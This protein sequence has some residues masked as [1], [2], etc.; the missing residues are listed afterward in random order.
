[1]ANNNINI[2]GKI[3][4]D[5][6]GAERALAAVSQRFR[7][8]TENG[9]TT[10]RT[11]VEQSKAL[12]N[13]GRAVK[14]QTDALG[15]LAKA[16]AEVARKVAATNKI[17]SDAKN[18]REV[19]SGTVELQN[20]RAL[21]EAARQQAIMSESSSRNQSRAT[22]DQIALDQQA[23]R[24]KRALA[25]A[26]AE[27]A[28]ALNGT[29]YALYDVARTATI[30]G[31]ALIA[32]GAAPVMV[33]AKWEKEFS[34]VRRTFGGT[35]EQVDVLRRSFVELAQ[36]IPVDWTALTEIGTLA[37]QLGVPSGQ[38]ADFTK[39][40]AQFSATTGV[41]V[42]DT[43]TALGR[44]NSLI[45]DVNGN[46]K[47]LA[48]SV[49]KVGV[50]SV[51][52]EQD[53]L[54]ISTQ[55]SFLGTQ[56][57][58]TSKEIVGLSGALASVGVP[59][60]LS[61]GVVT[62]TFG[63][64]G[65]AVADGG[66]A[67]ERFGKLAGMSGGEFQKAWNANAGDTFL[68]FMRGIQ[69]EGSNAEAAIR[70]L[71]ITSVRDVPVLIR[72]ANAAD[73]AGQKGALLAQTF[74]DAADAT[75]E[76]DRQYAIQ[77]SNLTDRIALLGNNVQAFFDAVGSGS[78]GPIGDVLTYF[79]KKL[80]ELTAFA[81]TDVGG[82]ILGIGAA[83]SILTGVL[84]LGAA[85]AAT[86]L[87]AYIGL[88]TAMRGLQ[89]G[90]GGATLSLGGLNTMLAATGPAGT[91]AAAGIGLVAKGLKAL[92]VIGL[93]LVVPEVIGEIAKAL[94]GYDEK[95]AKVVDKLNDSLSDTPN[96]AKSAVHGIRE[97]YDVA[98]GKQI[99]ENVQ[100]FRNE[101][102]QIG[103]SN[104]WGDVGHK[105]GD[106]NAQYERATYFI[107]QYSK[108]FDALV[109]QGRS[110]EAVDIFQ[111]FVKSASLGS[112]EIDALLSRA[113][114]I[115]Q[116]LSDTLIG[117]DVEVND[118]NLRAL[119]NGT[120]PE[121]K[122]SAKAAA[123]G[124]GELTDEEKAAEQAHTD[125]LKVITEGADSFVNIADTWES[126]SSG[127]RKA[128][129]EQADA[130]TDMSD[131][132]LNFFDQYSVNLDEY[133]RS[134]E[135]QAAAQE[136]WQANLFKLRAAG[137]SDEMLAEL[138]KL[139]VQGAP[140]VQ[141]F[142]DGTADKMQRF[143]ELL[144]RTGAEGPI[145]FADALSNASPT[146]IAAV[147]ALGDD[148]VNEIAG[149]LSRGEATLDQII[150]DYDLPPVD[151]DVDTPTAVYDTR[152]T[153]QAINSV[154]SIGAGVPVR[155][156]QSAAENAARQVRAAMQAVMNFGLNIPVTTGAHQVG[157]KPGEYAVGGAIRG[158]GTSTSDSIPIM[159]SDGEFMVR[160][161][162][163]RSVGPQILNFINRTGTLPQR[164]ATGG[165][166]SGGSTGYTGYTPSA[167]A[168]ASFGGGGFSTLDATA[169]QAIMAL[170]DRPI[171]LYTTDRVLAESV[172]RG[173][174][175]QTTLG[176]R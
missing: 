135:N 154:L 61:R 26:E 103:K 126:M 131:S 147:Q 132:W 43:A 39:V 28:E 124:V 83:V 38:I 166:V 167:S 33:A 143:E 63:Q 92:S 127:A 123:A 142:V 118:T 156:D 153:L 71:G 100:D 168:A 60:E 139:G 134:L 105:V 91:K 69:G 30:A 125:W 115:K 50:N 23:L 54:R 21:T 128:A 18:G 25:R 32:L 111:K 158:P 172:S 97:F 88:I 59:P 46:Y 16:E 6:G 66:V 9:N 87:A 165:Q 120:L 12:A 20:A 79:T 73:S 67:V 146:F 130:T 121:L 78:L 107:D 56:T 53:I 89:A 160:A 40:V 42:D 98:G 102:E 137:A 10:N 116:T 113:S 117:L 93:L 144:A 82:W 86:G 74:S 90:A 36:A 164:L 161:A 159:A 108:S 96:V 109:A 114:T 24:E 68:R 8:L 22:R 81:S 19:A 110:G 31:G 75:G 48:E 11:I 35:E 157:T 152:L 101:L 17:K 85:A 94:T 170:A 99:Y 4:I 112:G 47:G 70:Q 140:L 76:L 34:N 148:A 41:G 176:T 7:T 80:Q 29:R 5:A 3:D 77:T 62:R 64:I 163:A 122:D 72:L 13:A 106:A 37:G 119:A 129:Q 155:I 55:L 136:N 27:H 169:L 65:R 15:N 14:S 174:Q 57:T 52:T 1:M 95:A 49:L 162:A 145:L 44:L 151:V 84:L 175:D 2:R 149:K 104:F 58:F 51:A 45:P 141:A 150:K 133:L 173:A 138:A 171:I